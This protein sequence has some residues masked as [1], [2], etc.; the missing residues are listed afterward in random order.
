MEDRAAPLI[1]IVDDDWQN[2]ELL[3]TILTAFDYR[4][5]MASSGQKALEMIARHRPSLVLLDVRMPEMDGYE[6]CIKLRAN[7]KLANTPVIMVSGLKGDLE[8]RAALEAGA[9]DFISRVIPAHDLH[10]RI[11][12]LLKTGHQSG[13]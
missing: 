12:T 2:R 7:S 8:K 6:V 3:E 9:S 4:V 1:L 5:I 11:Q 10:E 13:D